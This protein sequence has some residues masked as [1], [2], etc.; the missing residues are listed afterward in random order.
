MSFPL[1]DWQ[2][3]AVTAA[4]VG[5]VWL[6]VEPFVGGAGKK[7]GGPCSQCGVAAGAPCGDR[8]RVRTSANR[9]LHMRAS[10]TPMISM[11]ER[12]KRRSRGHVES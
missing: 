7:T 3:W 6:L 9:S 12:D 11:S 5:A 2:F 10:G 1:A 4:A 8:I